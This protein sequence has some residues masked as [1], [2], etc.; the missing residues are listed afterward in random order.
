MG[1]STGHISYA[2][3][4]LNVS[5]ILL[6]SS[7]YS[8]QQNGPFL[9]QLE[10]NGIIIHE[11]IKVD[12]FAADSIEQISKR[13]IEAYNKYQREG[14]EIICG[15]TGGTNL[16]AIGMGLATLATGS[17]CH[18]VAYKNNVNCLVN[19]GIFADIKERTNFYDLNNLLQEGFSNE[20]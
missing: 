11:K 20:D 12:P 2:I 9:D 4:E 3:D 7:E 8:Y 15:L 18:Y 14:F 1:E 16:M 6:I 10:Q 13:I 19:I 5:N 17:K